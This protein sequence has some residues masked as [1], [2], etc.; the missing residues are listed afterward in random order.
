MKHIV[1]DQ[2][3]IGTSVSVNSH[4]LDLVDIL[5]LVVQT[6]IS[7]NRSSLSSKPFLQGLC[8]YCRLRYSLR[9]L[10]TI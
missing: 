10:H 1:I 5:L 2:R 9:L 4:I 6:L 7:P 3:Q 8:T